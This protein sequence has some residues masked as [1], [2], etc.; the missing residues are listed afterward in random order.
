MSA[1]QQLEYVSSSVAVMPSR[2]V[3][4]CISPISGKMAP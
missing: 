2:N 4:G 1:R 3:E